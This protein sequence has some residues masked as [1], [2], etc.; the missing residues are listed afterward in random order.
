MNTDQLPSH[1]RLLPL[2]PH[3]RQAIAAARNALHVIALQAA[4]ARRRHRGRFTRRPVHVLRAETKTVPLQSASARARDVAP[5]LQ[6]YADDGQPRV[7]TT[8]FGYVTVTPR[9]ILW[10][11]WIWD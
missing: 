7:T 1:E 11:A 10:P 3:A 9:Y 2:S 4:I 5:Q 6:R 8:E